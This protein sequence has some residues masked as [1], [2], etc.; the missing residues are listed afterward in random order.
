M[1]K[2]IYASLDLETLADKMQEEIDRCY[3]CMELVEQQVSLLNDNLSKTNNRVADSFFCK[4]YVFLEKC[5]DFYR[6]CASLYSSS[7]AVSSAALS[8]KATSS[9]VSILLSCSSLTP[10]IISE[11]VFWPAGIVM[12]K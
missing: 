6:F 3:K 10:N 9:T 4:K 8:V 5:S 12:P 7:P 11:T 1:S 2:K